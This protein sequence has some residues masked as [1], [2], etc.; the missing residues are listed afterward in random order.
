MVQNAF[1]AAFP[2]FFLATQPPLQYYLRV[3]G[4]KDWDDVTVLTASWQDSS[5]NPTFSM[6]EMM[7]DAGTLGENVR[8]LKVG[9]GR[10]E[11]MWGDRVR[12]A[13]VWR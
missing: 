10:A 13:A 9:V 12:Q 8:L 4:E 3:L 11:I 7:A 1:L 2:T 5:I 6:L